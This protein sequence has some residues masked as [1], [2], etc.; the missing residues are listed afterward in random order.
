MCTHYNV[1][2]Y[3]IYIHKLYI[4]TEIWAEG[5]PGAQLNMGPPL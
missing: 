1:Y 3:I 4:R 5:V 2:N